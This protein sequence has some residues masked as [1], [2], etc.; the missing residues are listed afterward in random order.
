MILLLPNG[1]AF[2]QTIPENSFEINSLQSDIDD[3]GIPDIEDKCSL[4]P[5]TRNGF[6]DT[7][8]CPDISP[9]DDSDGDGIND[10]YD[11]CPHEFGTESN[12]CSFERTGNEQWDDPDNDKILN[13]IDRCPN[14]YAPNTDDGCPEEKAADGDGDGIA[15]YLDACPDDPETKNGYKDRDGCPDEDPDPDNDKILGD[16]QPFTTKT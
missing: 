12:G 15:D 6:L 16:Y 10:V 9:D 3:D 11:F 7:D 1:L 14:I 5:E 4:Q 8:G 2:G 13:P